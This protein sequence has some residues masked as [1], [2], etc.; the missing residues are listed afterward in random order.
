MSCPPQCFVCGVIRAFEDERYPY[1]FSSMEFALNKLLLT[2]CSARI[3][4]NRN[5]RG[6]SDSG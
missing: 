6:V 4:A 5:K 3:V 2:V 1:V